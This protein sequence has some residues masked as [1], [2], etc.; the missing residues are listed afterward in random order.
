MKVYLTADPAARAARRA[1][2]QAGADVAATQQDLLRR[3]TIDS[4]RATSPLAMADDARPHRHARRTPSTRSSTRSSRWCARSRRGT[5]SGHRFDFVPAAPVYW[6][7]HA[8]PRTRAE[9]R[10]TAGVLRN[11]PVAHV[12][13]AMARP[14]APSGRSG[15]SQH[16]IDERRQVR[17]PD[18]EKQR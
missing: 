5:L 1:A 6:E 4:G 9:V 13:D 3:D 17:R 18:Q 2:E 7:V 16:D 14:G 12:V 10:R 11:R 8:W 15:V